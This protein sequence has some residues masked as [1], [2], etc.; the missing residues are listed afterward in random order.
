MFIRVR[1]VWLRL[2]FMSLKVF[3]NLSNSVLVAVGWVLL[4]NDLV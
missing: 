1:V 4:H 3:S 2:D